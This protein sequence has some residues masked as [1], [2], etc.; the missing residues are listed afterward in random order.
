MSVLFYWRQGGA[1][2]AVEA[3][4]AVAVAV[5][6]VVDADRAAVPPPVAGGAA[7][8]GP[9]PDAAGRVQLL[10]A[11]AVEGAGVLVAVGV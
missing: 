10:V 3:A 9:A 11:V 8:D 7:H 5:A 2:V 4:V 6:V 1:V